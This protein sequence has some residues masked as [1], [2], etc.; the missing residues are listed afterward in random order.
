MSELLK[1]PHASIL[2]IHLILNWLVLKC[3]IIRLMILLNRSLRTLRGFSCITLTF[4]ILYILINQDFPIYVF[5]L[6]ILALLLLRILYYQLSQSSLRFVQL[7]CHKHFLKESLTFLIA[8]YYLI[9]NLSVDLILVKL[10]WYVIILVITFIFI[11]R[12][13]FT[14]V[15]IWLFIVII[16]V[17]IGRCDKDIQILKVFLNLTLPLFP[18]LKT[19]VDT[20]LTFLLLLLEWTVN[21]WWHQWFIQTFI[22]LLN[23]L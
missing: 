23:V 1:K 18:R 4:D 21:F 6:N 11:W 9:V 3:F 10:D 19:Y 15:V 13:R 8:C 5:N 20:C 16:F 17:K 12:E 14:L 2:R 22:Y 7:Y